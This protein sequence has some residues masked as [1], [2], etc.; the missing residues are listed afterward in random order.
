MKCVLERMRSPV[1]R[2]LRISRWTT[3]R[4][5]PEWEK[6][7]YRQP[8][9]SLLAEPEYLLYFWLG[10]MHGN[11]L[12]L[13]ATDSCPVKMRETLS[14]WISSDDPCLMKSLNKLW[15][16]AKSTDLH[17][18]LCLRLTT[19]SIHFTSKCCHLRLTNWSSMILLHFDQIVNWRVFAG[20][21]APLNESLNWWWLPLLN[22]KETLLDKLQMESIGDCS[23]S[24]SSHESDTF[25]SLSWNR[26]SA[27]TPCPDKVWMIS[28]RVWPCHKGLKRKGLAQPKPM[29][30]P[31]DLIDSTSFFYCKTDFSK[32]KVNPSLD[33]WQVRYCARRLKSRL[34][35]WLIFERVAS[36]VSTGELRPCAQYATSTPQA[37]NA[38]EACDSI[39]AMFTIH[40]ERKIRTWRA[41][42]ISAMLLLES[43]LESSFAPRHLLKKDEYPFCCSIEGDEYA[44]ISTVICLIQLKTLHITST[45]HDEENV[46]EIRDDDV[47]NCKGRRPCKVDE[48]NDKS[49]PR[50][51]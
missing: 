25:W 20:A 4:D 30:D 44:T 39:W 21:W 11:I 15:S 9:R 19:P 40:L 24:L 38:R 28:D 42:S 37:C 29:F 35:V 26:S 46:K 34:R 12:C 17:M 16:W 51:V 8:L 6:E 22:G 3:R 49:L 1:S 5:K 2:A 41:S 14:E 23:S 48:F 32:V 10:R 50:L 18:F 7:K 47:A 27:N 31:R 43:K 33:D 36:S 45:T 13:F